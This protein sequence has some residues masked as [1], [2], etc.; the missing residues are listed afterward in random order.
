MLSDYSKDNFVAPYMSAFTSA[1]IADLSHHDEQQEHWVSNF[2]LNTLLRVRVPP[3]S[4]TYMFNF[5][6][7]A[8]AA[9]R[10]YSLAR[11]STLAY[12]ETGKSPSRYMAA[13]FH[14]EVCL[15]QA[16]HAYEL[17]MEL[18]GGVKIFEKEDG[19]IPQRLN[20]LY[21]Q[22]KHVDS[23]IASCQLP[24]PEAT[25]PVWLENAGLRST[26]GHLEFREMVEILQDLAKWASAIEDPSTLK[27][28]LAAARG[29][30]IRDDA[31]DA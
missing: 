29:L 21:N 2:I 14:W 23:T 16:W 13:V 10:E 20:L 8:E 31:G 30:S 25:L 17:L 15:S 12:L 22:M 9:F 24:S 6:R 19:T 5:L 7:R 1:E 27:E 28:Q 11:E 18:A 26:E 4:R 3:P